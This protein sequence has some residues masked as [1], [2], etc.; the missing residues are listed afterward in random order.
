[1]T[2]VCGNT[3]K[4]QWVKS[5]PGGAPSGNRTEMMLDTDLCL[6]FDIPRGA[7]AETCCAWQRSAGTKQQVCGP[8][9]PDCGSDRRLTGSA[10]E[11]VNA[12]ANSEATWLQEFEVAWAQ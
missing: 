9:A 5:G 3:V 11:H 7:V 10:G 8:P 4:N 12:F 1:M 2:A 6:A